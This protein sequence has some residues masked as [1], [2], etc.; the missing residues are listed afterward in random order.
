MKYP[1]AWQPVKVPCWL[2][3]LLKV[4]KPRPWPIYTLAL[5]HD[6]EIIPVIN[7]IDLPAADPDRV[8][9]ELEESIGLDASQAILTSAKTGQGIDEILEAI[10][11]R[12]PAP[13]GDGFTGKSPYL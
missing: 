7:K 4:S 8:K 11:K 2:L 5:E 1:G 3:M 13:T 12:I 9:R 10:V 6:L